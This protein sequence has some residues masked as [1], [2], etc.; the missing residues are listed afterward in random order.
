VALNNSC[1]FNHNRVWRSMAGKNP[2]D[3][4]KN[5]FQ[6]ADLARLRWCSVKE[7]DRQKLHRKFWKQG[8]LPLYKV[9]EPAVATKGLGSAGLFV[10]VSSPNRAA[11]HEF[12]MWADSILVCH[13]GH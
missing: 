2:V 8:Q 10:A 5:E 7:A 3:L 1:A 9:I 13:P 12:G 11:D 4:A 6:R